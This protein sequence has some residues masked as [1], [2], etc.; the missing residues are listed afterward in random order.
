MNK[1]E[2]KTKFR[3]Y[4]TLS[5]RV[6]ALK[7]ELS[8]PEVLDT[9]PLQC[10]K[11]LVVVASS[12]TTPPGREEAEKFVMNTLPQAEAGALLAECM[13]VNPSKVGKALPGEL[14]DAWKGI[15]KV[16]RFFSKAK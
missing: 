8:S 1:T 7:K 13:E 16:S 3:E 5:E 14:A 4:Y 9:L 15:C 11:D 2:L 6:E 12:R 10:S